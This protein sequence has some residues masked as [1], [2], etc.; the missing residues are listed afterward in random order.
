M[1]ENLNG[2]DDL[3]FK[4]QT[5]SQPQD[6]ANSGCVHKQEM[7]NKGNKKRT[8][9]LIKSLKRINKNLKYLK[10]FLKKAKAEEKKK[11][12]NAK[13]EEE[14]KK[15]NNGFFSSIKRAVV[16]AIPAIIVSAF[17]DA[18]KNLFK[19]ASKMISAAFGCLFGS[20]REVPVI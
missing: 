5:N 9:K 13:T 1:L 20:K 7:K 4:D 14:Q 11:L 17:K 18:C 12:L 15:T 2:N 8:K 19:G 6:E 10:K 3:I 16:I